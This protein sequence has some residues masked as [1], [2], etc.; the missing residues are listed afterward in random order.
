MDGSSVQLELLC[1]C[2]LTADV[3]LQTD[4]GTVS[5]TWLITSR[6]DWSCFTGGVSHVSASHRSVNVFPRN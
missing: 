1:H 2:C 6:S 5:Y 3:V 4:N